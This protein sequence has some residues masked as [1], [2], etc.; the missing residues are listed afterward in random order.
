MN[1]CTQKACGMIVNGET[2]VLGGEEK[3]NLYQCYF[4]HRKE[5]MVFNVKTGG[6]HSYHCTLKELR[7]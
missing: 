4:V 2:E 6:A 3:K 1:E 7:E 5:N